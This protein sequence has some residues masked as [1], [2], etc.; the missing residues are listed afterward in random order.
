MLMGHADIIE[1]PEKECD[2]LKNQGSERHGGPQCQ[3][4][5]SGWMRGTHWTWKK[6]AGHRKREERA[7]LPRRM[8]GGKGSAWKRSRYSWS[9][10]CMWRV[11]REVRQ[12][13][14]I[15]QTD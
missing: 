13:M 9:G 4:R 7:F 5:L 1:G 14:E 15:Y 8:E 2:V 6:R 11:G 12:N 3:G 10:L